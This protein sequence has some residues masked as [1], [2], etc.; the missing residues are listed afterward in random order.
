M[1]NQTYDVVIE[2][3]YSLFHYFVV[4][5]D[6]KQALLLANESHAKTPFSKCSVKRTH[7]KPVDLTTTGVLGSDMQ[8]KSR[9]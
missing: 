4:A 2:M 9:T 8:T 7:I 1:L 3:D 6:D 5:E